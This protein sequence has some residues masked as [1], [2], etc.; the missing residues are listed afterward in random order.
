MKTI[1]YQPL[2]INPQA[3]F[4]FPQLY[5]IEKGDSYIEP[6]NITGQLIINNLSEGL[7]LTPTVN[8]IQDSNQVDFSL[9]KGKHIRISQYTNIGAVVLGEWYIPGT[10]EPEQPDWFKESI[11]AWYSPC[12]QKLTNYDVIESYIIDFTTFN[13]RDDAIINNNKF[14]FTGNVVVGINYERIQV[15]KYNSYKI[16][17]KGLTGG[18]YYY[19]R[20][21]DGVE[22]YIIFNKDGV[23]DIPV[24]YKQG[25]E[26]IIMGYTCNS[27]T[28]CTVTQL[29]TS[30]LKDFSGNK[31]DAYLYGFKGKLNSGVGIY[32]QDFWNNTEFVDDGKAI[33][34]NGNGNCIV[35]IDMP[36]LDKYTVIVKRRWI[37]KKSENKW[38]CSLGSGDYTSVSQSLFWFEGGLLNNVFY[39][40]NRGYKNPIVLPE[41]ISI[42]SS[43]DYNGLHINE[44]NAVQAGNKLFIG[45]VGENDNTHVTADFY[46][47]LLFDR[48]LTDKEREW[49]KE[50]LIEPNTVSA[51]KACSALFEP[52]NLEIID[53]FPNGVIRDSLGGEY[54]LLPHSSDYTIENGLMKSTDDTFLISIENANENDVKAMI[55]DMYYDSTVPG[56]YLNGEYTE[57]SVKLTNR[58]IMGINNPTTTSIFQDLMQVLETG[59]T[60]G[61]IALYNKELNKDEFD[62]EAF[63]KGFAVR[64]STFEK[65]AT[66]HLFR[67]G[68][69]EL[70]PGEYLLPFE[71]LYLRVDV[72]EGYTMQDYVFDGVEQSWKP[73]TPKA[74]TC[75]EYD[76]HIIAMGEQVKVIKNWS[77]LTSISTFGFRATDNQIEFAGSTDGGTMS[78]ILDD[79]DV[80]KFTIEYTNTA[81]EGNVYLMI[82]DKQYDVIS[83][84]LQTYS[85]SGSVKLEFLNMEEINNFAGT[86]KF[87]NVN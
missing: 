82:G 15:E 62:S 77:P 32:A 75:P 53:E 80:T 29:P 49:V 81:G 58:R 17:I 59:F 54:Y 61:K 85:V 37:D 35:G 68:H 30:I 25:T 60:I 23:Y 72:P 84:Q 21:A 76:F 27:T 73:N 67:D 6:A 10:P 71:T 31:H 63:H 20:N 22:N 2:F 9:F 19:Y 48:V 3:Y 8:A 66:T 7:T 43:D 47:L 42:Q 40:Y 11:V 45:S 38:F 79:T 57:G 44:S 13:N 16:L 83:G 70:T 64:H 46:Q 65:D 28:E 50:N 33:R 52:E 12:K 1:L 74:Y 14:V 51:T 55:I 26:G 39:T 41:L 18:I 87:T 56:S 24:S 34:L 5:H 36:Q 4:V 86:I 69:K 78:Y